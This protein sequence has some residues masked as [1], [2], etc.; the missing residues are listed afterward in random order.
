MLKFNQIT[1]ID[2]KLLNDNAI[3]QL[4]QFSTNEIRIYKDLPD[5][6]AETIKRIGDADCV[7]LG[8]NTV[9]SAEAIKQC[10]KIKYIGLCCTLFEDEFSNVDL[11][12]VKQRNIGI[13][14]VTDYGDVGSVEFLFSELIA[15]LQGTNG[16]QWQTETRELQGMNIGII[17]M[18]RLGKKV[19]DL[20][21]AFGMN[22]FY[23]SR[24]IKTDS[25]YDKYKYLPLRDLLQTVDIVS[26]HVPR[27]A[28]VFNSED[29]TYIKDGSI[30]ANLSMGYPFE[31]TDFHKWLENERNFAIVDKVGV[32]S[33]MPALSTFDNVSIFNKVTGLTLEAK[34]R[35]SQK[36]VDNIA[37]FCIS[38]KAPDLAANPVL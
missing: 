24:T 4:S 36:V 38:I 28:M 16:S 1:C 3:E 13:K 6:E 37:D 21:L 33:N 25:E 12:T 29:F 32:G 14:G 8:F 19:A 26:F 23:N 20:A 27:R 15:Y 18:G 11:P 35:L 31:V 30:L 5:S 9:L 2:G 10:L 7:L 34:G 17:G 22:V